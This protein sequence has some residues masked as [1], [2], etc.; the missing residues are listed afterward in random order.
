M[1]DSASSI[2]NASDTSLVAMSR[3]FHLIAKAS[4]VPTNSRHIYR[5]PLLLM[6]LRCGT[7]YTIRQYPILLYDMYVNAQMI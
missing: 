7:I 6:V 3:T 4:E 5:V 2:D 1:A